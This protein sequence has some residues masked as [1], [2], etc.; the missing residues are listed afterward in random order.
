M[1]ALPWPIAGLPAPNA[2]VKVGPPLFCR[3]PSKGFALLK[4]VPLKLVA[5]PIRLARPLEFW[6]PELIVA[7][8]KSVIVLSLWAI[9]VL[10]ITA[11]AVAPSPKI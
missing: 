1:V 3:V 11:M 8:T 5:D 4:M 7:A 9:I 6:V 10:L 2:M